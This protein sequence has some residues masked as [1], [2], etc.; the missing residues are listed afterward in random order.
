LRSVLRSLLVT[1]VL[2]VLAGSPWLWHVWST[3]H[4]GFAM[5]F[6][7]TAP[8]AFSLARLGPDATY[9]PTNALVL[10]LLG[11]SLVA[12]WWRRDSLVQAMTIWAIV[13]LVASGPRALGSN[14]DTVTVFISLYFPAATIIGW[15]TV[16]AVDHF[17]RGGN[18]LRWAVWAGAAVLFVWGGVSI[19]AIAESSAPYVFPSDLL[20]MQWVAAHTPSSARFMVNTFHFGFLPSYVLGSDAG[21]WLPLLAGRS[22]ITA[23][24]TYSIEG[25]YS[26]GFAQN[27]VALDQLDGHLASPQAVALLQVAGIDYVFVGERGGQIDVAELLQSPAF[28]EEYHDGPVY[29]FRFLGLPVSEAAAWAGTY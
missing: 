10:G 27:L 12:G 17:G 9:Y 14:M 8:E 16:R 28:E 2:A 25:A 26:P 18:H 11:M 3:R 24:M 4:Q 7:P 22:T 19:T 29:V 23:P 20:A 21:W 1:A 15:M 6:G 13:L 5:T